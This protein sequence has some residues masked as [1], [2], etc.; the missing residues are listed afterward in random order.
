M[1]SNLR[2]TPNSMIKAIATSKDDDCCLTGQPH[3]AYSFRFLLSGEERLCLRKPCRLSVGETTAL[4]VAL[5][6][7]C[8]RRTAG[9]SRRASKDAIECKLAVTVYLSR[10]IRSVNQE[11]PL[12][13][14]R[15]ALVSTKRPCSFMFPS[16][17]HLKGR[18]ML[19]TSSPLLID[20]T[21]DGH[22]DMDRLR[23]LLSEWS[24][25]ITQFPIHE[26]ASP[27]APWSDRVRMVAVACSFL[28][29]SQAHVFCPCVITPRYELWAS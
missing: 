17:S 3:F 29:Y 14:N 19:S 11:P 8:D 1:S 18:V 22:V 28:G 16:S 12:A 9:K 10:I 21:S 15:E 6:S 20:A 25:E 24:V 5:D 7:C 23:S 13:A 2:I 4:R 27:V 26:I